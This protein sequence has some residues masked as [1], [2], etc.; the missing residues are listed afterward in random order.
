[1]NTASPSHGHPSHADTG[2]DFS[3]AQ[4]PRGDHA[5]AKTD[6]APAAGASAPHASTGRFVSEPAPK[7]PAPASSS[8]GPI[9]KPAPRDDRSHAKGSHESRSG[10]HT[11]GKPSRSGT[12]STHG[13]QGSRGH[14][15]H[16]KAAH[17]EDFASEGDVAAGIASP[18][19]LKPKA[20][21]GGDDVFH[22]I[23]SFDELGLRG[24]VLKGLKAMGFERPTRIQAMLIPPILAGKDV[25][26]QAKTGTGKTAAFGLPILSMMVKEIPSQMLVLVPTRELAM[27]V[28][29]ELNELAALTPLRAV[30]VIGGERIQQ[31][32]VAL[33]NK[34][35]IIVSTPG[36]LKDM[37][38]RGHLSLNNVKFAVLDEVDRM[39]DIGFRDDIREILQRCPQPPDRQTVF[40]S[41]TLTQDI[42]RLI[43]KQS[44][45]PEKIVAVTKGAL[46]TQ[47]VRQHYLAVQPW[48]KKKLLTH[49]L[50][51]EEGALTLV[52][53]RMKRTVDELTKH[54]N[55][56]GIDAHAMH[57]DMYQNKR[58][59]IIERLHAGDLSVLVASDLASR[60]LDVDGISHVINYDMPEDPEV[61]VHRIGRTARIGREGI[62]WSFV[63]PEQGQLL[64]QIEKLINMEIPELSFPDFTPSAPPRG[65]EIY[66]AP[67]QQQRREAPPPGARYANK[68]AAPG[69]A[70]GGG[71]SGTT[72]DRSKFPGGAVPTKAPA[73]RMFG[74][75][76]GR[77][78][79]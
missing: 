60:G 72:V 50:T 41:A 40:V 4:T 36:R 63:T 21:S 75:V 62:A 65:R 51:H 66:Q 27:Q 16:A 73:K 57:G 78:R 12:A 14:A 47:L 54:L 35:Q 68:K 42:E 71:G 64:T 10:G 26:G 46:T 74:K 77:G 59:K 37:V 55:E 30:A 28:A 13:N 29:R 79:R 17:A 67:N 70:A 7:A 33:K 8:N 39:L 53:C 11:G 3:H 31:Q 6:H 58:N 76:A 22:E 32:L 56:K 23:G 48:D 44:H 15:P 2:A 38:Q 49:L 19:A 5:R 69:S 34:P 24:S 43:H 18:A 52:F 25:I 9:E 1:M 20:K 61:Y 45:N